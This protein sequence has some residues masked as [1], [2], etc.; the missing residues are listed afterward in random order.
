LTRLLSAE[1]HREAL[2]VLKPRERRFLELVYIEGYT[3]R[4]AGNLL[5][6]AS[7]DVVHHR[8]KKKLRAAM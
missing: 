7:P 8:A 4:E 1:R 6:I 5:Q 3:I 2:E